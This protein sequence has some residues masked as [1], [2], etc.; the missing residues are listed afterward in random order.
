ME[1]AEGDLCPGA[2]D[3]DHPAFKAPASAESGQKAGEW[4]ALQ[5]SEDTSK[6]ENSFICNLRATRRSRVRM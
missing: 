3:L 2:M 4:A 6:T 5:C 1:P